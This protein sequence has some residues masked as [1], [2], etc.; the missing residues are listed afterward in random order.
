MRHCSPARRCVWSAGGAQAAGQGPGGQDLL[1]VPLSWCPVIGSPAQAN[2]NLA[3][4]TNT[5]AILWRRHERP[6]DNIYIN[7]VGI[8]FRSSIN[9]AWTVLD[10]PQLADPDTTLA[11]PG[12]MRGEDVNAFG[13]E[14]N[15]L[16]NACDAA[17]AGPPLNRANIG[18]TAVN[19][20]AFHD[21]AGTYVGVIGW[22]G[23]ARPPGAQTT[24]SAPYDGRIAVVDNIYLHP[25][26]PNRLLPGTNLQ[27]VL[28][29]PF[30]QLV[31]HELGH[32]LGLGH[33]NGNTLLMNPGPVDNN[34]DGQS[35]NIAINAAQGPVLRASAQIV[36]GLEV[37]PPLV[38]NPGD[39]IA[40]RVMDGKDKSRIAPFHNLASVRLALDKKHNRIFISNQLDG[41]HADKGSPGSVHWMVLDI[42]G[43]AGGA[44]PEEVQALGLKTNT[45]PNADVVIRVEV[46]YPDTES[47]S[48]ALGR[49]S[50]RSASAHLCRT[51]NAGHVSASRQ[52]P[53]LKNAGYRRCP[54]L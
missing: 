20:G 9:N 43:E 44:K 35:D 47:P 8:S 42:D 29:D 17:Y 31:G 25:A 54:H 11:T 15:A 21:A 5:D 36:P 22:G 38:I 27:F 10:F 30:D 1:H 19:A 51:P 16:I 4:D 39:F 53:R 12:D 37:D 24:C 18:V 52:S 49:R 32:A 3:G 50:V 2:P 28:T 40:D 34:G 45:M 46:F 33:A 14:F 48:M 6:T 7:T 41:V 26:S 13:V 23:C